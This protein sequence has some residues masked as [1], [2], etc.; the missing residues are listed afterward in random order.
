MRYV[1]LL[2]LVGAGISLAG[3]GS[4][5]SGPQ[6]VHRGPEHF[7]GQQRQGAPVR[8]VHALARR[9]QLPRPDRRSDRP[10]GPADPERHD[11][12]E[13]SAGERAGV[14]VGDEVVPVLSARTAAIRRR[15]RAPRRGPR[16][17]RWRAACARTASPT[18][19]IPQFATGPNGGDRRQDRRSRDQPELAGVPDRGEGVRL[20]LRRRGAGAREARRLGPR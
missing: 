12:G 1:I 14:Q 17:S 15:P 16:H 9:P 11:V 8:S 4:S 6:R 20:D 13:R 3:C 19:P 5:S 2:C 18:S 10:P 7:V